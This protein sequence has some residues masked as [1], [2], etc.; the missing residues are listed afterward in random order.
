MFR[1]SAA[2]LFVLMAVISALALSAF[3]SVQIEKKIIGHLASAGLSEAPKDGRCGHEDE[4]LIY[5]IDN[6]EQSLRLVPEVET[7]HVE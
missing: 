7:T 1:K 3:S 5:L 6:F 4:Y 2:I